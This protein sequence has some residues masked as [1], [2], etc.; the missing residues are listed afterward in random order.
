MGA[1]ASSSVVVGASSV[2]VAV[3]VGWA[4]MTGAV[5]RRSAVSS[6]SM[7]VRPTVRRSAVTM[8]SM[9]SSSGMAVTRV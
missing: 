6:R 5:M 7:A 9:W 3:K 8:M 2:G 4:V 1:S